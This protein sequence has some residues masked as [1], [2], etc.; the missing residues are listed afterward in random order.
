M[1]KTL[2]FLL[3]G[4][5]GSAFAQQSLLTPSTIISPS[6]IV[7]SPPGESF[8]NIIDGT[9]NSKYLDFDFSDGLGFVVQLNASSSSNG[10][11]VSLA[12]DSPGRDPMNVSIEGST[13]GSSFTPVYS[14]VLPCN[15]ARFSTANY[16][17][18]VSSS[19]LYYRVTFTNRCLSNENSIQLSEFQLF[20]PNLASSSFSNIAKEVYPNPVTSVLHLTLAEQVV[21]RSSTLVD[22][23]GV[24]VKR[25]AVSANVVDCSNLPTGIYFLQLESISGDKE[26]LKIM[27]I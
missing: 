6:G 7:N 26:T 14:G 22:V 24:I 3:I 23:Q 2:H 9:V 5:A 27:K 8:Q 16:S 15:G 20:A 10:F 21:L 25:N 18:A 17:Y 11:S 4:L 12:N 1:K 19:Y 13:N